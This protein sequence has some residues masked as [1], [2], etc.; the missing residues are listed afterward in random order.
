MRYT[1]IIYNF[2]IVVEYATIKVI[3]AKLWVIYLSFI[4][5]LVIRIQTCYEPNSTNN[6]RIER[7]KSTP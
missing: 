5:C 6:I 3:V 4:I 2:K 7:S 1:R